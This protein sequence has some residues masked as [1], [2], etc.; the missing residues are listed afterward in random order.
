MA[1]SRFS[2][3]SSFGLYV[4]VSTGRPSR[5]IAMS[6]ARTVLPSPGWLPLKMTAGFEPTKWGMRTAVTSMPT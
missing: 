2:N 1:P 3:S 4:A 6:W 5:R